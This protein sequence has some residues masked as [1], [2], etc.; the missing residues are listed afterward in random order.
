MT[1]HDWPEP[2]PN[3]LLSQVRDDI[4]AAVTQELNIPAGNIMGFNYGIPGY[5][6]DSEGWITW[7][8]EAQEKTCRFRYALPLT[9]PI[10]VTVM[11][12]ETCRP[13]VSYLPAVPVP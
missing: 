13:A 10:H 5:G 3:S 2:D 9:E 8:D 12:H 7:V 4:H 11:Q 1:T 6:S